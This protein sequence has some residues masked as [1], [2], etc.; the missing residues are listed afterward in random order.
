MCSK[1]SKHKSTMAHAKAM[2]NLAVMVHNAR[3]RAGVPLV[4]SPYREPT[5]EEIRKREA[6]LRRI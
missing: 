2:F 6:V 1:R 3:C 5:A 4:G